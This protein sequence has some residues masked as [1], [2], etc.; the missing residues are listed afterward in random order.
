MPCYFCLKNKKE[1]D[2]QEIELLKNFISELG[3]IKGRKK[4]GF[5][6]QHQKKITKAIK[7]A[8]HLGL[9]SAISK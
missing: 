9:L 6:A 4:T 8:R 7:R 5:C 3:K 2:F 1:I